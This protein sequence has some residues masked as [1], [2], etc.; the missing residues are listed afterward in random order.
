MT[1]GIARSLYGVSIALAVGLGT[2]LVPCPANAAPPTDAQVDGLLEAL[3]AREMIDTTLSQVEAG[4][5]TTALASLGEQATPEQRADAERIVAEEMRTMRQ[6]LVWE[7]LLPI[8]HKAY[9]ETL[10]A[11]EVEAALAFFSSEHGRS[12]MLKLPSVAQKAMQAMQP[13][14]LEEAERGRERLQQRLSEESA[15]AH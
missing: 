5:R 15:V 12:I 4:M 8:Y 6:M 13:M 10:T 3:R 9:R 11:E 14:L 7:R 1:A 2:A